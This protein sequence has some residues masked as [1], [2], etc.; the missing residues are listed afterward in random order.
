MTDHRIYRIVGTILSFLAV[1]LFASGLFV[2]SEENLYTALSYVRPIDSVG[3]ISE[4]DGVLPINMEGS[5]WQFSG[6]SVDSKS[7]VQ[8]GTYIAYA[9]TR[10][11]DSIGETSFSLVLDSFNSS[12]ANIGELLSV[13][14][15]DSIKFDIGLSGS[16]EVALTLRLIDRLGN[17]AASSRVFVNGS[18]GSPSV[19]WYS[20]S[21]DLSGV[22]D[23]VE[24]LELISDGAVLSV[25]AEYSAEHQPRIIRI[26]N[27]C[28][29]ND[30]LSFDHARRFLTDRFSADTG[31]VKGQGG[32][33]SPDNNSSAIL[34][35]ALV[36]EN[37]PKT[38]STVFMAVSLTNID[39]GSVALS[40]TYDGLKYSEVSTMSIV[41]T[42]GSE[43]DCVF[44]LR[45]SGEPHGF[46]LSF[47]NVECERNFRISSIKL[48]TNEEQKLEVTE[49]G[50]D[51]TLSRGHDGV[52]MVSGELTHDFIKSS[53]GTLGF[54]AIPSWNA[55]DIAAAIK[56]GETKLSSRFE[57]TADLSQYP[58]ILD[59]Y[60]VF[61]A[62]IDQNGGV[63]PLTE[64]RLLPNYKSDGLPESD[65]SNVGLLG[66]AVGVF[67][68]N[69]SHTIVD[70]SIP[71]LLSG[72]TDSATIRDNALTS[73]TYSEYSSGTS[74]PSAGV[75]LT[76]RQVYLNHT[77]LRALDSDINFHISSGTRVYLRLRGLA[78]VYSFTDPA[79]DGSDIQEYCALIHFLCARYPGI[80]GI[81]TGDSVN[82]IAGIADEQTVAESV[83]RL[84]ALCVMTA[85]IEAQY[86]DRAAVILPFS[87]D[88]DDTAGAADI[89]AVSVMLSEYLEMYGQPPVVMMYCT[90]DTDE[91][92][93][94]TATYPLAIRKNLA[95]LGLNGFSD[96][97][98]FIET[99]YEYETEKFALDTDGTESYSIFLARSFMKICEELRARAVFLSL[100][101]QDAHIGH[102]FY[103]YIKKYGGSSASAEGRYAA[104]F[105]ASRISDTAEA[106]LGMSGMCSLYDFSNAFYPLDWVAGGDI[107][108]CVTDYSS[109][110]GDYYADSGFH[111]RM[112][113][114]LKS[115]VDGSSGITLRNFEKS[116]DLTSVDA[117]E[118][119]LALCRERMADGAGRATVVF[120]IGSAEY[121]AEFNAGELEYGT[122]VRYMCDLSAYDYNAATDYIGIMVYA[123][124]AVTLELSAVRAYS[125]TLDDAALAALFKP[126]NNA[127]SE[128]NNT[129]LAAV[130]LGLIA[131][132][133]VCTVIIFKR[134]DA[135]TAR[136]GNER[137]DRYAADESR[138]RRMGYNN[139]RK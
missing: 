35:G 112:P 86:T 114:V 121:R 123:D 15:Y 107:T 44:P 132:L 96:Y 108:S 97:M 34:R 138:N 45:L 124:E 11:E 120:V 106:L 104:D 130:M 127:E 109:V 137:G 83:K 30:K 51:I 40:L 24:F 5:A 139:E 38:G 126:A 41:P 94:T 1:I 72:G 65:V 101:H 129:E 37:L 135:E 99:T 113:R 134:H 125:K 4:S 20:V 92:D 52:V 69:A 78:D 26:A 59:T 66:S 2:F 43:I 102:D 9:I 81:I 119:T 133:S 48:Y 67:E 39:G 17:I 53:T 13:K 36:L 122:P 100:K 116:V 56:I 54:F 29:D 128:Q 82:T 21:F 8:D 70:V 73:M 118:F 64:P 62:L 105:S 74:E 63:T 90:D 25:S 7:H 79:A 89:R 55:G 3:H 77:L 18:Y 91:L 50:C 49:S 47:Q 60:L 84:A 58:D 42:G 75:G 6:D 111:K 117:V 57:Y 61:A 115:Y 28:F 32:A 136:E 31:R 10:A 27:V 103:Y 68:S 88:E 87:A 46:R 85:S 16:S 12:G 95:D 14:D 71:S 131:V 76:V 98:Y 22:L 19:E 23:S 80:S 110:F 93:G 33:V